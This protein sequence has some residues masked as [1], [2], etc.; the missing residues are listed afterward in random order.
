M[1]Y[2]VMT[3][4]EFIKVLE[5]KGYEYDISGDSIIINEGDKKNNI[6]SLEKIDSMPS[7][8]EFSKNCVG[9][10]LNNLKELPPR[11]YFNNS[12]Y[13]NLESLEYINTEVEFNNGAMIHLDSLKELNTNVKF[14]NRGYVAFNALEK[15]SPDFEFNNDGNVYFRNFSTKTWDYS[16]DGINSTRLLNFVISKGLLER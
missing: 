2:S 10:R 15:I 4:E 9:V 11:V 6:V 7:D 8:V 1:I 3:Q 16:I 14:N 12:S 5:S 13:V